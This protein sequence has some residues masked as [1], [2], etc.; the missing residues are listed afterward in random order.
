MKDS[1]PGQRTGR[2]PGSQGRQPGEVWAGL[3][4]GLHD[5]ACVP[6]LLP[7]LCLASARGPTG[8]VMPCAMLSLLR[9]HHSAGQ[10]SREWR[11]RDELTP[12][13]VLRARQLPMEQLRKWAPALHPRGPLQREGRPCLGNPVLS[14]PPAWSALVSRIHCLRQPRPM[15]GRC[16]QRSRPA[17]EPRPLDC[18]RELCP[19]RSPHQAPGAFCCPSV[20]S[21]GAWGLCPGDRAGLLG[22][23]LAPPL[24]LRP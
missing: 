13:L 22:R 20:L 18:S 3:R 4:Q 12:R 8:S 19:E 14:L 2:G 10:R 24:P 7:R 23:S 9:P 11:P 17:W 21:S 15:E 1:A 5:G 16:R 6:C